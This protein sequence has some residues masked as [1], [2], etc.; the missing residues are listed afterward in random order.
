MIYDDFV[1]RHAGEVTS[2]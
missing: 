2:T 1:F